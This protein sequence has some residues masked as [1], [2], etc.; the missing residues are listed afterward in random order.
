MH[1]KTS[2]TE[3]RASHSYV[4]L[5]GNCEQCLS[6]SGCA[7]VVS[8]KRGDK[9]RHKGSFWAN[10]GYDMLNTGDVVYLQGGVDTSSME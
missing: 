10:A 5:G 8:T 1:N 6:F 2:A 3:L 9:L 7:I 4:V